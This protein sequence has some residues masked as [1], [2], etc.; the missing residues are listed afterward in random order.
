M[1]ADETDPIGH[2]PHAAISFEGAAKRYADG[3]VAVEDLD[4]EVSAG[5]LMVFVGPSGCGKSTSLRMV[6]RLVELTAGRVLVDG[7]DVRHVDPVRLR[8]RIGYVIQNVGLFPHRTVEQNVGVVPALLGW[9]RERTRSRSRELLELVGL[10]ADLH[11]RRYPH[12]LS[13]GQRQRV[14]VARALA[15]EPSVLLMDEPFGAVD[16]VGRRRLQA[17]FRRL[18]AELGTTVIFVTH[19]IDEAVLLGDRVAVFR[20]GGHVEQVADPVTLLAAPANETVRSFIG[21][22]RAV[23]LLALTGIEAEDLSPA[24]PGASPALTVGDTL[25]VALSVLAESPAPTIGVRG[26][27]GE[28]VGSLDADAIYRALR[29]VY[30]A[31]PD[32]LAEPVATPNS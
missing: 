32:P 27:D 23:R 14:G 20:Q 10:D 28:L 18:H 15:A 22:D 25:D 17:E 6:N 2:A 26:D 4:L 3:T 1:P 31:H 11:A 19:D 5:E 7:E 13:G 8:R 9:S 16:P 29:R 30:S 24:A 21:A 12:E